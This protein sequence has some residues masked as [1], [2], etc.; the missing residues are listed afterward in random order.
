M[1]DASY[2]ELD[3]HIKTII[4]MYNL[5]NSYKKFLHTFLKKKE[6]PNWQRVP[7]FMKHIKLWI[8]SSDEI[9]TTACY[10]YPI[11]LEE[12]IG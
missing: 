10:W 8:V 5:L 7:L 12:I 2:F 11:A 1:H 9:A 4:L 3:L 6:D